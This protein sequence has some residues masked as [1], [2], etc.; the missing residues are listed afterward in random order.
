MAERRHWCVTTRTRRRIAASQRRTHRR[1]S[2]LMDT[3][4]DGKVALVTGGGRG[5]GAAVAL[6][7]AQEGADVAVNFQRNPQSAAAVVEEIK[8]GGHRTMAIQADSADPVALIAAVD[9]AAAELGRLDILVN[10]A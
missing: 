6:R 2:S 7:L 10:N 5:I 8:A 4:F 3:A 1:G 9:R